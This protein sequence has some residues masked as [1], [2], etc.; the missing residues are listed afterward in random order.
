MEQLYAMLGNDCAYAAPKRLALLAEAQPGFKRHFATALG[1]SRTSLYVPATR[2]DARDNAW[3]PAAEERVPVG[4]PA[5]GLEDNDG[6]DPWGPRPFVV[7]SISEAMV[8]V[9]GI[10]PST[11]RL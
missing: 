5:A 10:E 4:L 6:P 1:I 8:G 9:D 2:Q 3:P 11:K 7:G